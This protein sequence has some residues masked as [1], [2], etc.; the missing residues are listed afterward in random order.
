MLDEIIKEKKFLELTLKGN[1]YEGTF[2]VERKI[3]RIRL[4]D[5]F[6]AIWIYG[7]CWEGE[8]VIKDRKSGEE[9]RISLDASGNNTKKGLK[10]NIIYFDEYLN[11]QRIIDYSAIIDLQLRKM[12]EEA[13]KRR[14]EKVIMR[15]KPLKVAKLIAKGFVASK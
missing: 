15:P 9:Q 11:E 3:E 10:D 1:R 4:E 12:Y 5:R 7:Y 13:R 8:G 14:K 6:P 2:L